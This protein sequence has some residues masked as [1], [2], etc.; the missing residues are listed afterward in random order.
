M[1]TQLD[2][3]Q[4]EYGSYDMATDKDKWAKCFSAYRKGWRDC[5]YR[6]Q[7][8]EDVTRGLHGEKS[9]TDE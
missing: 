6:L 4:E 1:K 8:L 5:L 9:E 2:Y 3:F 7:E